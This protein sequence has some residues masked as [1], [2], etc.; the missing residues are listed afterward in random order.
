MVGDGI[1]D[2]LALTQAD[3]G[4]AFGS[5]AN[6]VHQACDIT[7]FDKDLKKIP[8]MLR[9]SKLTSKIIRENLLFA[10]LYN[11]LGIPLAMIG[12]LNPLIAVLAMFASSL[13]VI[14]NTL[15]IPKS[16]RTLT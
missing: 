12:V 4:I 13:T 1:N 2:A 5:E 14:G 8:A 6:L 3:A 9:L 15:R 7:I 16:F 10:F 11:F